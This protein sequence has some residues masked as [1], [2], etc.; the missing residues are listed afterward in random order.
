MFVGLPH[1]FHKKSCGLFTGGYYSNNATAF[2]AACGAGA[3]LAQRVLRDGPG[4]GGGI[5]NRPRR[6]QRHSISYCGPE[7]G[8]TQRLYGDAWEAFFGQAGA[9][10]LVGSAGDDFSAEYLS[11]H[12]GELTMRQPNVGWNQNQTGL[13][14][15]RRR[16]RPA[17]LFDAARPEKYPPGQG[18]V[19]IAGQSDPISTIYPP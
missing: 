19:W 16:L 14:F 10:A 4:S 12:S 1:K 13:D 6:R 9:V 11:R 8:T 17:A 5:R 2:R 18:Y 3:D 7:P 15:G